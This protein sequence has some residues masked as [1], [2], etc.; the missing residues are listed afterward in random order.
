VVVNT[1]NSKKYTAEGYFALSDYYPLTINGTGI[2]QVN[3]RDQNGVRDVVILNGSGT[4]I[5]SAKPSKLSARANSVTQKR[6]SASGTHY[7]YIEL[8][9][10]SGCEYRIGVDIYNQ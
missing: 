8:N 4:E 1:T 2:L 3:I 6:I 10:R 9:G 5:M 7:M